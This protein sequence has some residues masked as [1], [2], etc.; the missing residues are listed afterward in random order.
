MNMDTLLLHLTFLREYICKVKIITLFDEHSYEYILH[1]FL[2]QQ[3]AF[4][5]MSLG[6]LCGMD[7]MSFIL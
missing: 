4:L 6:C 3:A 2:S 1:L 7:M 5:L